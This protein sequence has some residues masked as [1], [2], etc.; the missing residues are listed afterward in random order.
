MI[1]A[2]IFLPTQGPHLTRSGPAEAYDWRVQCR[3]AADCV[4]RKPG[5]VI[6]VPSA[7]QKE[8]CASELEFYGERL[9]AEGVPDEAMILELR[10]FDTVEQCELAIA[11]AA[12]EHAKLITITCRVQSRRVRYLMRGAGVEHIIAEGTPNR[13][14]QFTNLALGVAFPIM[15][16]LG[17]REWWKRRVARRRLGGKQ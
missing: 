8:G 2:I 14:L 16:R 15:D 7:F 1:T 4:K 17:L 3:L 9:R 10:G 13:W 6:Y 12:K 5:S 11:F